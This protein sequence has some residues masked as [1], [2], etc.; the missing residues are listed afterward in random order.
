MKPEAQRIAI[1]DACPQLF[2][3]YSTWDYVSAS[4]RVYLVRAGAGPEGEEI[5]PLNDL[6]AM[7]EV[8]K[9]LPLHDARISYTDKLAS[10]C[11]VSVTKNGVWWAITHAT[12]AQRAEA[13]LRTIGK[14]EPTQ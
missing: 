7:H 12:A 5:D 3:R 8:E 10:I 4:H 2:H 14:W 1:A 6:N 11:V 9:L 13:F